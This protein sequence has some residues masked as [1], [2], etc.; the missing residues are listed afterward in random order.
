[1]MFYT[2]MMRSM[3]GSKCSLNFNKYKERL[4]KVFPTYTE[5]ELEEFFVYQIE[6]LEILIGNIY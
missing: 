3:D 4:E 5:K 1:M 6:Y 2:L